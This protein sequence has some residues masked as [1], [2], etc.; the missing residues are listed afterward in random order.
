MISFVIKN[1]ADATKKK[2]ELKNNKVKFKSF[3]I[4]SISARNF[5]D[6]NVKKCREFYKTEM[7]KGV[8]END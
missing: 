7:L 3:E 1:L 2:L 5:F 4:D 8:I 6:N